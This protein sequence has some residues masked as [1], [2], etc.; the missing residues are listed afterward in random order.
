M[1]DHCFARRVERALRCGGVC[2][3]DAMD[4]DAVRRRRLVGP[5][6]RAELARHHPAAFVDLHDP[7]ATEEVEVL[8]D[9]AFRYGGS[10]SERPGA[11][12]SGEWFSHP[13]EV[14]AERIALDQQGPIALGAVGGGEGGED[15]IA[16]RPVGGETEFLQL[17]GRS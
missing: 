13:T 17:C 12:V 14:L 9:D 2:L 3:T 10:E 15:R 7:R 1:R 5:D 11:G 4:A 16:G 6:L 8:V